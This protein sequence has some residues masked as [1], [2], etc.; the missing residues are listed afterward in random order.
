MY[1]RLKHE[2]SFLWYVIFLWLVK[3]IRIRNTAFNNNYK[4]IIFFYHL[5]LPFYQYMKEL[6]AVRTTQPTNKTPTFL[7]QPL[8][9]CYNGYMVNDNNTNTNTFWLQDYSGAAPVVIEEKVGKKKQK[10]LK[11]LERE[12][13]KGKAGVYI[14]HYI[15]QLK[16]PF[17]LRIELLPNFFH[18]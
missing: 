6:P 8:S 4:Y 14:F 15:E 11:Q 10:K 18:L 3:R 13:T 12:K 9:N 1:L 7:Q 5:D 17:P 2:L 16:R